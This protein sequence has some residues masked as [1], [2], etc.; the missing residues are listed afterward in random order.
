MFIR[1]KPVQSPH[2]KI[3]GSSATTPYRGS[4]RFADSRIPY[5]PH[6]IVTAQNLKS[7]RYAWT[8]YSPLR[9]IP[10]YAPSPYRELPGRGEH[11]TIDSLIRRHKSQFPPPV[12]S[13]KSS[14]QLRLCKAPNRVE[15]LA[16]P[17][18]R[19]YGPRIRRYIVT[20]IP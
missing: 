2:I 4:P 11:A 1:N 3:V 8:I 15:L 13:S 17:L 16:L 10:S 18:H 20:S 19:T 6:S 14:F 7:V 12:N 5:V 9:Y